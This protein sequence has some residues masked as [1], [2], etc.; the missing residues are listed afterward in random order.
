M[1]IAR[2]PLM[3]A[4]N[5]TTPCSSPMEYTSISKPITTA[6]LSMMIIVDTGESGRVVPGSSVDMRTGKSSGVSTKVSS[7]M[8]MVKH[9]MFEVALKDKVASFASKSKGAACVYSEVYMRHACGMHVACMKHTCSM[10]VVC[11]HVAC[12]CMYNT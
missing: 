5:S 1:L 9:V 8:G 2:D 6:S 7:R 12:I 10:H 3:A 11:M 4:H